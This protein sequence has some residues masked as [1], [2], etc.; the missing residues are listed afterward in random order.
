VPPND[1]YKMPAR[2]Q[3][4][5]MDPERFADVAPVMKAGFYACNR[6]AARVL[7]RVK[8]RASLYLAQPTLLWT[9]FRKC[10]SWI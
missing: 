10:L 8:L 1:Y 5:T 3:A 9:D 7:K 2:R 4:D 6:S